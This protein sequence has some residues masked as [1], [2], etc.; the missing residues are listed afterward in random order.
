MHIDHD[1]WMEEGIEKMG[2]RRVNKILPLSLWGICSLNK[3]SAMVPTSREE[4]P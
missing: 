2:W 1:R 4:Q 3:I